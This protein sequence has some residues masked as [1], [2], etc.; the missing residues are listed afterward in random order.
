MITTFRSSGNLGDVIYSLPTVRALTSEAFY[1]IQP[2]VLAHYGSNVSYH[3]SGPYRIKREFAKQLLP[4]L[5]AQSYVKDAK[6]YEG[7]TIDI[8]LELMRDLKID[9]RKGN[10]PEYY[11][12]AFG[13]EV[14]LTSPWLDAEPDDRFRNKVLVSRSHRYRNNFDYSFLRDIVFVGLTEEYQD[15]RQLTDSK[16]PHFFPTDHLQLSQAIKACKLFIGNQSFAFALAE[17][18]KVPRVLEVAV[19][20]PNVRTENE[21]RTQREFER[22]IER[23]RD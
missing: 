19:C 8:D 17:G 4:L 7:E 23:L 11:S 22:M 9:F 5:K 15:Y 10:L 14:D 6:L 18:L 1:L 2:E 13:V 21:A 16:P 12:E 3:P 20:S